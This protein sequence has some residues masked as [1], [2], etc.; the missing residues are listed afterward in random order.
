[1]KRIV[2]HP[3]AEQELRESA[4]F[5]ETKGGV[6]LA[7]AF[8]VCL[9]SAFCAIAEDPEPFPRVALSPKVQKC[10]VTRFPFSVYYIVQKARIWILA[11]AHH[12]R[13]PDYW[14]RRLH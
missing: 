4:H 8:D 13:R 3:E 12:K 9:R 14:H 11:L 2:L 7:H 1:M 10:K 6:E 5:Y